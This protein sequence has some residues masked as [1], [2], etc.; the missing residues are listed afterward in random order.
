[1]LEG[2]SVVQSGAPNTLAA[3]LGCSLSLLPIRIRGCSMKGLRHCFSLQM[4]DA[5]RAAECFCDS[6]AKVSGSP[7]AELLRET[8]TSIGLRSRTGLRAATST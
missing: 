4:A 7:F 5:A 8:G 1:M 3:V 6:A 2:G